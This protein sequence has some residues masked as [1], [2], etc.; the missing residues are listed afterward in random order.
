MFK[1]KIDEFPET[2][3]DFP[4]IGNNLTRKDIAEITKEWNEAQLA[5]FAAKFPHLVISPKT[6]APKAE[7]KEK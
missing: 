5:N 2:I 3:F 1:I 6:E 4:Y 7:P